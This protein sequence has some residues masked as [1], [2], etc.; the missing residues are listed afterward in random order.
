MPKTLAALVDVPIK[1]IVN[2]SF[3]DEHSS[4]SSIWCCRLIYLCC[5]CSCIS[6]NL[7]KLLSSF[8][9]VQSLAWRVLLQKQIMRRGNVLLLIVKHHSTLNWARRRKSVRFLEEKTARR[10]ERTAGNGNGRTKWQS[11]KVQ[12]C[13][14]AWV[15]WLV[16]HTHTN[17]HTHQKTSLEKAVAL[18]CFFMACQLSWWRTWRRGER[19]RIWTVYLAGSFLRG[20]ERDSEWIGITTITQHCRHMHTL[21]I[22]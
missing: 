17:T 5:C 3:S 10:N 4:M 12:A 19:E 16:P 14:L 2:W 9:A 8:C 1:S 18:G 20:K 21:Q 22:C 6:S 7:I 11:A 13:A 15:L